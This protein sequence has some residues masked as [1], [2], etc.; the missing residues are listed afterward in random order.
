MRSRVAV[1]AAV[2][3]A[4][5]ALAAAVA[6]GSAAADA[7]ARSAG[8]AFDPASFDRSWAIDN[9]WLPLTPGTEFVFTGRSNDGEKRLVFTVTDLVK[10]V[11]GVRNVVVWDRDFT[12]GELVEAELAFFAQDNAGNVWHTGEYPE[13]YEGGK[14]VGIPAWLEGVKGASAGIEMKAQP[15]LG[16]PSY[17]QGFAPPPVNWNDHALIFRTGQKVCV[18]VRCYA[19]VLITREYT[20]GEPGAQL[21]YYAAG[22][23]NVRVG[24]AGKD[25]DREAVV[26]A[27]LVRLSPA[28]LAKARAAALALDRRAYKT[29]PKVYGQT[30]PA[31]RLS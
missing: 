1:V 4:A 20:P 9:R 25:P 7:T 11:G 21:K 6:S 23:G 13:E 17:P 16:L 14:I 12:D 24:W 30:S 18:P 27:K 22:T 10:V 26:L 3:A 19:D 31:R 29:R 5:V 8:V 2:G 28:E 15:R